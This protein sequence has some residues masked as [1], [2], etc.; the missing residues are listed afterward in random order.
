MSAVNAV[1]NRLRSR[2]T[3]INQLNQGIIALENIM[4]PDEAREI[5]AGMAGRE[6]SETNIWSSRESGWRKRFAKWS[7]D[8]GFSYAHRFVR[9]WNR[10][11]ATL[12]RTTGFKGAAP[13]RLVVLFTGRV[14]RMMVP[15]WIFLAHLPRRPAYVLAL[16]GGLTLY[17]Q[18]LPGLTKDFP[19]TVQWIRDRAADLGLTVHTVMGSSAGSLPSLRAGYALGA[20][21]RLVFGLS[22]FSDAELA[23][24]SLAD[25]DGY[26]SNL[27]GDEGR[28]LTL[29]A[30]SEEARDMETQVE[31]LRR[32]P[33]AKAVIVDGAGHNVVVP[34]LEQ[35]KLHRL[36]R[37][38]SGLG[39]HLGP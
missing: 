4:T 3:T 35:R 39:F 16:R 10:P 21:R 15:A 1:F 23:H 27:V 38:N 11:S 2:A 36:L 17:R 32:M 7:T 37:K 31:A 5:D 6:S 13:T 9:V 33:R 29:V 20:R 18:G 30:G 28:G 25:S 8:E 12:Y 22:R 24:Y 14:E 34:L 19:E 26:L